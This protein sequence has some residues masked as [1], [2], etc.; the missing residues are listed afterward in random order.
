MLRSWDIVRDEDGQDL[1]EYALLV[2]LIAIII[3]A[4]M[5]VLGTTISAFYETVV[6][7]FP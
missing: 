4:V 3:I 7:A 2:S 6:S 1:F 5:T